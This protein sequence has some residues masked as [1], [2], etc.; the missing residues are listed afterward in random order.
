[1]EMNEAQ[2][3]TEQDW[4]M[5]EAEVA[6]RP[7][8]SPTPVIGPLIARFRSGWNSIATQWYVRPLLAQQNRF[9]R[10]VAERFG[11]QDG[12]LITQDRQQTQHSHDLAE[13]SA[14]LTQ[15]NRQLA[16]LDDRLTQLEKEKREP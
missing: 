15:L 3:Q 14:L 9:N 5:A 4:M 12:R 11:E 8:T 13:V 7:F 2:K 16:E 1:M 10:L 6:E